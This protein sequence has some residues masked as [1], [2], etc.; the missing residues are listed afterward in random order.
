MRP[1]LYQTLVGR[2]GNPEG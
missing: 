2:A 1:D